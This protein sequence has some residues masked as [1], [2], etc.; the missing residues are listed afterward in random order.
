MRD[1]SASHSGGG[2]LIRN[3]STGFLCCHF[4]FIET[5]THPDLAVDATG[6]G[7]GILEGDARRQQC[8]FKQQHHQV[9]DSL[10]VLVC[11]SLLKQCLHNGVV[12][13]DLQELFGHHVAHHRAIPKC[14]GFH[15][16]PH[17]G[18]QL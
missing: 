13:V 10:A 2:N 4:V 8:G 16:P 3:G 17:V 11:L 5:W 6:V 14:L 7:L 18:F 9:L 1:T 12:E 15:D